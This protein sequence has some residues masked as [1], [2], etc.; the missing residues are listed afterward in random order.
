VAYRNESTRVV[1]FIHGDFFVHI[2]K[3]GSDC[4]Y[5]IHVP[6]P[7]SANAQE[8]GIQ[9][10]PH[11]TLHLLLVKDHNMQFDDAVRVHAHML[12]SQSRTGLVN[13]CLSSLVRHSKV[14]Q[15]V[16]ECSRAGRGHYPRPTYTVYSATA[17][18]PP[19]HFKPNF[20]NVVLATIIRALGACPF[21]ILPGKLLFSFEIIAVV[22]T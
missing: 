9:R 8:I 22:F 11:D 4:P 19:W 17:S 7:G 5:C 15:P 1:V 18:K 12:H 20:F 14:V 2:N 3:D 21:Q 16:V 6:D 13:V 10:V